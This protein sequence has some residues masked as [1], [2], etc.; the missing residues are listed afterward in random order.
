MGLREDVAVPDVDERHGAAVRGEEC[1]LLRGR[2]L[3]GW[4]SFTAIRVATSA[5]TTATLPQASR[6]RLRT[7]LVPAFAAVRSC[8]RALVRAALPMIPPSTAYVPDACHLF[9]G[10]SD[11]IH[12]PQ[13]HVRRHVQGRLLQAR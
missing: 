5:S 8:A 6:S 11:G 3:Q 12:G 4:L 10:N 7:A 1:L 2:L 13:S 9:R